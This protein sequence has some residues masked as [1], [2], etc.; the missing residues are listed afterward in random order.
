MNINKNLFVGL[1]LLIMGIIGLFFEQS[2]ILA[3]FFIGVS[4]PFLGKY[5]NDNKNSKIENGEKN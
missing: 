1:S 4:I 3:P 2:R 5:C